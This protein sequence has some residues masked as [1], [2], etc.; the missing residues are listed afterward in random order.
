M[1]LSVHPSV[2]HTFSLCFSHHI[3]MKFSGV[4]A[5]GK[6][7]VHAKGQ[8]QKSKVKVIE[9]KT[10]FAGKMTSLYWESPD[11]HGN[12]ILE[13]QNFYIETSPRII[14]C[15]TNLDAKCQG[16]RKKHQKFINSSVANKSF[17]WHNNILT[18]ISMS[19]PIWPRPIKRIVLFP[20][21]LKQFSWVGRK[22]FLF[23]ILYNFA[24][25]IHGVRGKNSDLTY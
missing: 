5:M 11:G 16:G 24:C 8:G 1:V 22:V 12:S 6:N 15:Q 18:V 3:I 2:C 7:D 13:R 10:N 21:H 9:V 20:V 14:S 19:L 17:I 25:K 4:I 23:F